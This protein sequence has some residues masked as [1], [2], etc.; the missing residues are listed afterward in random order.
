MGATV[1]A[2]KELDPTASL[3]ALYGHKVRKLRLR[4]GWTQ[5]E[6]G[7]KVHVTH[8]RI[9]KIE[10]GTETLPRELS[11]AL[12]DVLGAD[13]DLCDLWEHIRYTPYP[14]WAQRF[15]EREAE[16][17]AMHKYM[18]QSIP[19]ILQTQEYA[20]FMLRVG[21]VYH[22]GG[23]EDL[24]NLLSARLDRQTVLSSPNPPWLW[25]VLDEAV[26]HRPVGGAK[27]MQSQLGHLLDTA[28]MPRTTVQILPY[29]RGEHPGLGGSMTLLTLPS[30]NQVV[31]L[32][33]INSGTL[34]EDPQEIEKYAA[35][36]DH[37][38]ANALPPDLSVSWIRKVMEDKYS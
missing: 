9:A 28:S 7:A 27:V 33:G 8:S 25:V 23:A 11:D 16:A 6:L 22:G 12:D 35:A 38:Q 17:T 31:Y 1:P 15:M 21:Q 4:A 13:G 37:L 3:A 29:D 10:L 30:R 20:H 18:A 19:G 26:L 5:R 34:V 14:D 2:P 36:Y 24:S 32:E